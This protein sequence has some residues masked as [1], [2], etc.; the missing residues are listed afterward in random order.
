MPFV[1]CPSCG[2]KLDV[3]ESFV[4]K[5]VRCAT[6]SNVFE[7][8]E[9][10]PNAAGDAGPLSG[11]TS[12]PPAGWDDAVREERRR[13]DDRRDPDDD[14]DYR[15]GDD[16]WQS[17][18][19]RRDLLPHRGGLI[20]GLGIGSVVAAPLGIFCYAI[21]TVIGI[22]L[23]VFAWVM[24]RG[25]M[26]QMDRGEMDP[27]GRGITQGGYICGI[28]GTSLGALALLACGAFLLFWVGM[29]ATAK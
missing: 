13:D 4:G 23:G 21:P 22:T 17:R 26:R 18:R 25:D 19:M 29:M 16:N 1:G 9:D 2:V 15:E 11:V 10:A 7:A 6:C 27:D 24:G 28:I 12:Q 8:K 5:K 14:D 3:P 20:L